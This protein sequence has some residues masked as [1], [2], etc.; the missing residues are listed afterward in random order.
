[1]PCHFG[2]FSRVSSL[3]LILAH[4][5][6]DGLTCIPRAQILIALICLVVL[7][8]SYLHDA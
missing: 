1:M 6:F 4:K 7:F 2:L 8:R 3:F 5:P